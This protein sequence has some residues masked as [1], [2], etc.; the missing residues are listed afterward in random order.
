[1]NKVKKYRVA[2]VGVG[3]M[4]ITTIAKSFSAR[5]DVEWI[6][7]SDLP[8]PFETIADKPSSKK[9][10][11][12]QLM[13]ENAIP[14]FF[15]DWLELLDEKPDILLVATEN[16]RHAEVVCEALSRGIHVLIEKPFAADY[17]DAFAMVSAAKKSGARLFINWPTGWDPAIRTGLRLAREGIIGRPLKFHYRNMESLGPFS[18]GQDLTDEEKAAE[19]WYHSELGGGALLDYICY[20]ANLSRL[21]LGKKASSAVAMKKNL[22]SSFAPVE[23]HT[24]AVLDFGDSL[25]V[26]EGTW[27]TFSSGNIDCGPILFGDKGTLVANRLGKSVALYL[28]RHVTEPTRVVP[29]DPLPEGR[30]TIADEFIHGIETGEPFADFFDPNYNL[31]AMSALDA[32]RRAAE[33]G[34]TELLK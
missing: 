23:D 4:H 28:E 33:S 6:G 17:E 1:M 19:W 5:S 25:A 20:G 32:V 18:Y 26:L 10:L 22:I 9:N 21:F 7:L 8:L 29:L 34:N 3:Q 16:T 15:E 24:A 31:D 14:R 30:A 2:V 27:A 13:R 12:P 11:V